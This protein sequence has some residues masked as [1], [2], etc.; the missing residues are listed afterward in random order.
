M[1]ISTVNELPLPSPAEYTETL[2]SCIVT[3]LLRLRLGL[4]LGASDREWAHIKTIAHPNPNP[5]LFCLRSIAP[6]RYLLRP[7]APRDG[8]RQPP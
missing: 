6:V 5:N 3:V 2:Q 7:A 1:S 8:T 4:G